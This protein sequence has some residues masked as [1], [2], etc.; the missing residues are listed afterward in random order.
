MFD[1]AERK[2]AQQSLLISEAELRQS[3]DELRLANDSLERASRMK[4]EF[5]ASMSHELRTPLTGILGLSEALQLK[6]YGELNEKQAKALKNIEESGRHLLALINDIL[7]LSKIEAGKLDLRFTPCS[8]ADVCQASLQ[9]IKGMA[10]QKNQKVDYSPPIAGILVQ[11]DPRRIKQILVNLL[12]NAVKFT[13][14]GGELGLEVCLD[15][16]G[17][18]VSLTVWDKGIGIKDENLGQLFQPFTQIDSS[19]TR[20]YSGSGLGLSLVSRLVELHHGSIKVESVF[21]EG[22][23]FTVTLPC[24]LPVAA[25]EP[26]MSRPESEEDA[27][28]VSRFTSSALPMIFVVDDAEVT[29]EMVGDYLKAK[30]YRV[31]TARSGLEFLMQAAEAR[32]DLIIM[33]IQ[34]PGMDGMEAIRQIRAHADPAVAATPIIALTALVMSGDRER[35][36]A[37]GANDYMSKPVSLR[38]LRKAIDDLLP[39]RP[40]EKYEQK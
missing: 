30:K 8:I 38:K 28:Q 5:L 36:L 24:S 20:E 19:L 11:A 23:R 1:N 10:H 15:D 33:D 16:D 32:P 27:G 39:P 22:S 13:S 31:A 25:S 3:R 26:A 7:D 21:G 29:L 14:K 9:L 37:A 6:T 12:S 4:D 35:C 34:M 18:N 2:Q 40:E 17:R